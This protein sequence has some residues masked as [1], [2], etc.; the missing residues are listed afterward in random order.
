VILLQPTGAAAPGHTIAVLGVGLVGSALVDR[1]RFRREMNVTWLPLDWSHPGVRDRQL[2]NIGVEVVRACGASSG[3][4]L[5]WVWSAGRAGFAAGR[6]ETG[7]EL[8]SFRA[9]LALW[10]L[11]SDKLPNIR[12]RIVHFSSAGGLFEGQRQVDSRAVPLP[13][14]PYGELKEAEEHLILSTRIPATIVRLSS[15][16]GCVRRGQRA[17]LVSTLLLNGIRR[18]VSSIFGAME[19]LRDFVWAGDVAAFVSRLILGPDREETLPLLL[20]SGRPSSIFEIQKIIEDLLGYKI[21]ISCAPNAPN[22]EDITFARAALPS[23][24]VSTD[25][26]TNIVTLY[27]DAIQQGCPSR[28]PDPGSAP[29]SGTLPG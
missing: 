27:R 25:L 17:G 12:V 14:R 22:R 19:T 6:D 1:L 13:R 15:V 28:S 2:E 29:S 5:T 11:C 20:A 9:V 7:A 4:R 16:Y 8:A 18:E 10:R 24:W 23:D 3:G 21:Y 26:K